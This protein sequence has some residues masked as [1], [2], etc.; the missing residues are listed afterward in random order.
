MKY[1]YPIALF[2]F[3]PIIVNAQNNYLEFEEG[4]TTYN[5]PL[6]KIAPLGDNIRLSNKNGAVFEVETIDFSEEQK[7]AFN[8]ALQLWAEKLPI[9]T[10]IYVRAK[11][12]NLAANR[13]YNVVIRHENVNLPI[14][15]NNTY[16]PAAFS[17]QIIPKDPQLNENP[18]IDITFNS[19]LSNWNFSIDNAKTLGVNEIDFVTIALRAVAKGLGFA[20][21]LI[22]TNS[23]ISFKVLKE[24]GNYVYDLFCK[25]SQGT[26][27]SSFENKSQELKDFVTSGDIY[28][29]GDNRLK[30]YSPGVFTKNE[31]LNFFEDEASIDE[32]KQLMYYSKF[33][34]TRQIGDKVQKVLYDIGWK[35]LISSVD[36]KSNQIGD[37]GIVNYN[38]S[39]TYSF[40]TNTSLQNYKWKF[41]I[42]KTDGTF[43]TISTGSNSTFSVRL[44]QLKDSYYR[45]SSGQIKGQIHVEGFYATTQKTLTGDF[46]MHINYQP[47]TPLFKIAE[48]IPIDE[49]QTKI[50][51]N[52][53]ARGANGYS[54]TVEDSYFMDTHTIPETGFVVLPFSD[55]YSGEEYSFTL[56]AYNSYGSS[57]NVTIN[58]STLNEN[59]LDLLMKPKIIDDYNVKLDFYDR[60]EILHNEIIVDK[61]KIVNTYGETVKTFSSSNE[62]SISSLK[63]GYYIIQVSDN[64]GKIYNSKFAKQ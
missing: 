34:A 49:Y 40:Y 23:S 51:F 58:Y 5:K 22:G 15:Q 57:N 17:T 33:G 4:V 45:V 54:L 36:I 41:E 39:E 9:T 52:F 28:W 37:N 2:L 50:I 6:T 8:Y 60:N 53:F 3:C 14:F 63:N 25:S 12:A 56:R 42:Q 35:S 10:P 27:L 13:T 24:R 26:I 16:F 32:A 18:E 61:G 20:N 1:I 11:F 21:D 7:V 30:L 62:I 19:A 55:I 46:S 59:S 47:E 43:E 31:S 29:N 48:I 64:E 38:T 44:P